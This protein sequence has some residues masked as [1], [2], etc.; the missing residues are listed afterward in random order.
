MILQ[1]LRTQF[2]HTETL[3]HLQYLVE[4]ICGYAPKII[5][6]NRSD[7]LTLGGI[8]IAKLDQSRGRDEI[9]QQIAQH[10]CLKNI[11]IIRE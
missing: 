9:F 2:G 6:R 7:N 11:Q 3:A 8:T 10:Q 1:F 4:V 5:D